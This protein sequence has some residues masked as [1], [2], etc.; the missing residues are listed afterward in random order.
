MIDESALSGVVKEKAVA[1]FR[2]LA[3][4]A[5]GR[6]WTPDSLAGLALTQ[7]LTDCSDAAA[8][9]LD[10]LDQFAL[11]LADAQYL[12][13]AQSSRARLALLRGESEQA[14]EWARSVR[15]EPYP[16]GLFM[17]LEVPWITQARALIA[18]GTE[19]SLAAALEL[20]ATIRWQIPVAVLAGVLIPATIAYLF[21]AG[22]FA[23]PTFHAFSGA[24]ITPRGV[25]AAIRE[26]LLF[27][28]DRK[29]ALTSTPVF[30]A[31]KAED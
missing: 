12:S 20:L 15:E 2:R 14:I 11:E 10:L 29:T 6:F 26:G 19:E 16:A 21:D 3:E 22:R 25:V 4:A 17:F 28:Q 27:F 8:E 18:E 13:V 24:T 7:Q 1:L 23:P 9:S 31:R 30:T 5:G